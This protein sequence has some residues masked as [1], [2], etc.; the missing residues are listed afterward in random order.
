MRN[1]IN[2]TKCQNNQS[3]PEHR[4]DCI[5]P[6]RSRLM[7][8]NTAKDGPSQSIAARTIDRIMTEDGR[9]HE[10]DQAGQF[11]ELVHAQSEQE[12]ESIEWNED[13]DR[14]QESDQQLAR[15]PGIFERLSEHLSIGP[16]KLAR[17]GGQP[18]AVNAKGD[19]Q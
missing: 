11:P 10:A 3:P 4:P 13:G 8:A 18:E 15:S 16:E 12:E 9:E 14:D 1:Q 5:V 19:R 2:K 7:E 17:V 6:S